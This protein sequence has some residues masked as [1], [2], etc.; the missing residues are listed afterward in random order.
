M[1]FNLI[2]NCLGQTPRRFKM[3]FVY[4]K[5]TRVPLVSYVTLCLHKC[6]I[7]S[8]LQAKFFPLKSTSEGKKKIAILFFLHLFIFM[9]LRNNI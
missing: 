4:S 1:E 6:L 2:L 5:R 3:S 7:G 8:D 9:I